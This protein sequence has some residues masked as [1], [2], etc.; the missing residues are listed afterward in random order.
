MGMDELLQMYDEKMS[1]FKEGDIIRGRI[2]KITASEAVVDIGYK[3]EGLLPIAE[4]TG[5][6]GEIKGKPGD[7]IKR[8][9]EDARPAIG[10]TLS[11]DGDTKYSPLIRVRER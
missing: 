9:S 4:L 11:L 2:L 8:P 5:Y 1:K 7:E 3:S 10:T 6:N